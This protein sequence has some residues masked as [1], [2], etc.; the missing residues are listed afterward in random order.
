MSI[1][2][3][4]SC[5]MMYQS[6]R[7]AETEMADA[8]EVIE[9]YSAFPEQDGAKEALFRA[10]I[11]R[12]CR[13][14]NLP[15][16]GSFLDL[17]AARGMML[18]CVTELLPEWKTCAVELS[19]SARARL[20]AR[21]YD[22][23]AAIEELDSCRKFD[24]VNI[25]NVLEHLPD[26][27]GTLRNLKSRLNPG[28]FIYVEVPNESFL[29]LRYRVNDAIRGFR[30][31]PTAEGHINLFTPRTLRALFRSA[32]FAVESFWLES[33][34]VPHR[35]KAALG[36]NETP[37]VRAALQFLRATRLAVGLR[38]AYFLCARIQ[39]E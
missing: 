17:G 7:V 2:R 11:E 30:K 38:I 1:V 12:F 4:A 31:P 10:R 18:D 19:P 32:G 9:G 25:D 33:V 8:Y 23:S 16:R 14:R 37:R 6:P 26:P 34:S 36:A 24:W 22:C 28:G 15:A 21:K 20:I 5:G 39:A 29:S 27:A 3:C 13:E 35:L